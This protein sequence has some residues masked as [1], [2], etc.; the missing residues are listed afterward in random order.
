[1]QL[2]TLGKSS[3]EMVWIDAFDRVIHPGQLPQEIEA[4]AAILGY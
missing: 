4:L 1:M 3:C 2:A